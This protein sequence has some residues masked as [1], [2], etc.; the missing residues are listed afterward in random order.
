MCT[1]EFHPAGYRHQVV[2]FGQG[3]DDSRGRR[4][5]SKGAG[6]VLINPARIDILPAFPVEPVQQ[7]AGF[8]Q[9]GRDFGAVPDSLEFGQVVFNQPR[10]TM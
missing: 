2:M 7:L 10:R 1:V 4:L 5:V 3:F 8:S 9:R 6:A